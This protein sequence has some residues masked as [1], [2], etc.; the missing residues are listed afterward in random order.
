[1]TTSENAAL[2][3]YLG[4]LRQSLLEGLILLEGVVKQPIGLTYDLRA[5]RS[6][7][8]VA[9]GREEAEAEA[10]GGEGH[11]AA[12]P[13]RRP[14]P[15]VTL[16]QALQSLTATR[17]TLG[18]LVDLGGVE[19]G[20]ANRATNVLTRAGQ[21]LGTEL[22]QKTA[23]KVRGLYVVLDPQAARGRD[24]L[25]LAEAVLANGA[26]IIQLRD[27]LSEKGVQ[28]QTARR[29]MELCAKHDAL[30]I[31]NDHADLVAAANAHGLH[32]GQKDLPIEEARWGLSWGQLVGTSNATVEEAM[33]SQ[34][35]GAD[36]VA[37]GAMFPSPSKDNTRP[38]GVATLRKVKEQAQVPL[39]AIGGITEANVD[40]VLA[41]GA[42]AIAVVSAVLGAGDPGKAAA[43]L[44]ERIERA[45]AGR[46]PA[47]VNR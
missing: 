8:T 18:V 22:R 13:L 37:V 9:L 1:M 17:R 39:V 24:T 38:A 21:R 11:D 44:S 19:R 45:L 20:W 26:R 46:G 5:A 33:A 2:S 42:D 23:A 16:E 25:Q 4:A 31:V 47:P 14:R 29:L 12:R 36:Y 32:L 7:L 34:Q 30:L 35:K 43:R 6:A 41:A 28:L 15:A 27:K 40:E 10:D 3:P